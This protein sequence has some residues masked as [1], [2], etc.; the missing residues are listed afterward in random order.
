[1]M[2]GQTSILACLCL[3]L[4]ACDGGATATPER[5]WRVLRATDASGVFM[6]SSALKDDTALVV[7]GTLKLGTA[8]VVKGSG[9]VDDHPPTGPLLAWASPAGSDGTL[10]VGYG[11]R[12]LW[13]NNAGTWSSETTPAG[14]ELWGCKAFSA[15][16]AWAVG[17]DVAGRGSAKPVLLRRD[18]N[19]WSALPLPNLA[20]AEARL[21]KVDASAEDDVVA[22]G[23]DGLILGYDGKTWS[24]EASG[25]GIA[26]STVRSLGDGRYVAVGGWIDSSTGILL[27]RDKAKIWHKLGDAKAGLAGFDLVGGALWSCGVGGWLQRSG[28]DGA[29]SLELAGE[30]TTDSLHFVAALPGGDALSGGGNFSAWTGTLLRWSAAP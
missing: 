11:R 1:M 30:Q 26:L 12:A 13:R 25:T 5:T 17:A 16:S 14:D 28:L 19:G 8:F 3:C 2:R 15:N 9:L 4:G 21:Y 10:I 6:A 22:V 18:A 24:Q 27:L 7:G 23:T 29:T 20:A